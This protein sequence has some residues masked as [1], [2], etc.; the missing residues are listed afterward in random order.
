MLIQTMTRQA[1]ID[2]L[3]RARLGRLACAHDGQSYITPVSFACD[4]NYLYAFSTFGQKISWMR[5][6]PRVCIEAEELVT[7]ENWATV[8]VIGRY[9]EL[10]DAPKYE[11]LRTHAYNLL[12]KDHLWWEPGYVKTVLDGIERPIISTMYFRIHID[13]I[14]G[15]RGVPDPAGPKIL[16]EKQ[17]MRGLDQLP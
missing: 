17:L 9:E 11:V 15:H 13:Q 8:I 1:S 12:K 5:A 3:G 14:S 7:R 2:L 16:S 4:E 10:T 6:N